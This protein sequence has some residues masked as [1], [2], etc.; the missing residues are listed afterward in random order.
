MATPTPASSSW[1][2][3]S[4]GDLPLAIW[5]K[6]RGTS[7]P[8]L[9]SLKNPEQA[10]VAPLR[11]H[12]LRHTAASLL[13]SEGAH[14][15]AI[16]VHPGHSSIAVTMDRYGHLFPSDQEDLAARLDARYE[17]AQVS[18]AGVEQSRV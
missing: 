7:M 4:F 12:D 9:T 5:L 8:R 2:N 10:G 14:P 16:Q 3:V 6:A 17:A 18:P 15:K 1:L 13:I 11:I